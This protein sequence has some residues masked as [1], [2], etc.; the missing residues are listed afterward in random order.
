MD[1]FEPLSPELFAAL[2]Q[3]AKGGP[4]MK[5]SPPH[6]RELRRLGYVD[7]GPKGLSLTERGAAALQER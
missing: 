4:E 2:R 6:R 3:I 7:D 1:R 5:L